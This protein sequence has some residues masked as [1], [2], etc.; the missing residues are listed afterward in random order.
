MLARSQERPKL[1][2]SLNNTPDS[3]ERKLDW[4]KKAGRELHIFV[5]KLGREPRLVSV[6][7]QAARI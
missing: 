6:L 5:A 4:R 7:S 3:L 2:R 1:Q